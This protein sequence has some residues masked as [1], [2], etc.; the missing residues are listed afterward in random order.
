[1]FDFSVFVWKYPCLR[2]VF[3]KIKIACWSWN[4]KPRLIWICRIQRWFS[5]FFVFYIENT[6][7]GLVWSKNSKWSV[8]AETWY[9]NY[10]EYVKFNCDMNL[11]CFRPFVPSFVEE[12]HLAF[13]CNLLNLLVNYLHRRGASGFSCSN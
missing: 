12:I 9:L 11:F 4:L 6:L 8:Q 3:Q 10:F 7:F 2:K 13:W 5:F 1:M